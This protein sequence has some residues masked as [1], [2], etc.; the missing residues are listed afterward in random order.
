M[1]GVFL[2][3]YSLWCVEL[4]ASLDLVFFSMMWRWGWG[5]AVVSRDDG[6]KVSEDDKACI[7]DRDVRGCRLSDEGDA[8][9]AWGPCL[10]PG[11]V[12][13]LW[14]TDQGDDKPLSPGQTFHV[15][16]P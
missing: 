16:A 5:G 11:E 13:G 9:M 7:V 8:M 1:A 6:C 12:C 14:R 15:Y 4:Y 10:F 3:G 2:V